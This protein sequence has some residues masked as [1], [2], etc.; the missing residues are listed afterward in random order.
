VRRL[1]QLTSRGANPAAKACLDSPARFAAPRKKEP[2]LDPF[3][4]LQKQLRAGGERRRAHRRRTTSCSR[5]RW[6]RRRPNGTASGPRR[7]ESSMRRSSSISPPGAGLPPWQLEPPGRPMLRADWADDSESAEGRFG[8]GK[9]RGCFYRP[10]RRRTPRPPGARQRGRPRELRGDAI[11]APARRPPRP[12]RA[13][14]RSPTAQGDLSPAHDA[15]GSESR[16]RRA[17]H[18]PWFSQAMGLY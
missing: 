11:L 13:I 12:R 16:L 17:E 7:P 10:A 2:A 1:S 6:H 18:V 5:W 3:S 14:V 15:S 8:P 9:V 4:A